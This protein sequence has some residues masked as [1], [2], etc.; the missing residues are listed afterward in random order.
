MKVFSCSAYGPPDVLKLAERE[1]PVPEQEEILVKIHATTVTIA[2][3]RVRGF[4]VPPSFWLPARLTLGLKKPRKDILG[5]E[6]AGVVEETGNSV[7]NFEPG[8]RVFAFT[9]HNFGAYAE[10]ICLH[11]DSCIA[12]VPENLDF[13]E[14]AALSFGGITALHFLQKGEL[15]AGEEI[16]IY[17]ASGSV[18]SYAVQL[19][20]YLG[21]KVTAVCSTGNIAMVQELGAGQVIDYTTTDFTRL[22][23]DYDVIFDTVGKTNIR[24]TVKKI[25][26]GGRYIHAVTSPVTNIK[27]KRA[28]R[29]S[30]KKLVGGTFK[31][32]PEQIRSIA[33]LAESGVIK[34]FIDRSFVFENLPDAH[35]YVDPGHKRG[36]V[37]IKVV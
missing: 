13:E 27:L 14:A 5:G 12:A 15:R 8:E 7:T 29:N 35:R 17:G 25:R 10:Y 24:E 34:P 6:L 33:G 16:L 26:T 3:C 22:D 19:A 20:K 1:K 28:L 37:T 32:S 21:A 23:K 9:S 36:N 18:G 2:D 30:G 31:A 11:K 4:S